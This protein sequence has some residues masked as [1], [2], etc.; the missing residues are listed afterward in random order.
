MR[1]I[2]EIKKKCGVSL[3]N[4]EHQIYKAQ[5]KINGVKGNVIFGYNEDGKQHVSFN[6]YDGKLPSWET[7][8]AL[9]DFFFED[10]EEAIQIH[11]KKSEYV[12]IENACLHL[13]SWEGMLK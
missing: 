11:P 10:E 7:M 4:Q 9:K 8:C 6:P 5:I 12:N 13:W 2:E 1:T 3:I